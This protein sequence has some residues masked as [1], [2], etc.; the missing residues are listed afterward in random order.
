MQY[1]ATPTFSIAIYIGQHANG[2]AQIA[3]IE[4]AMLCIFSMVPQSIWF[5]LYLR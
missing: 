3:V 1:L 2:H 5:R 4:Q